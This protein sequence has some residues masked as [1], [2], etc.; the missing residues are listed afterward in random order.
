MTEDDFNKITKSLDELKNDL[1]RHMEVE[2]IVTRNHLNI[3]QEVRQD[4]KDQSIH[5][6]QS[7]ASLQNS[8]DN[9]ITACN[10]KLMDTLNSNYSTNAQIKAYA[11]DLIA[12]QVEKR[13][14]EISGAVNRLEKEIDT[15]IAETESKAKLIA[16]VAG[17]IM[18]IITTVVGVV[19][20]AV[21]HFGGQ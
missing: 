13:R 12:E 5:A 17:T 18:G 16:W 4:I 19:V 1:K 20:T 2:E 15:K 7:I 11:G 3:L 14:L 6:D 10:D 21:K 9:R 8:T